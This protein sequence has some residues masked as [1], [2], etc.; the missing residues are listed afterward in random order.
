M[1]FPRK[2]RQYTFK[3]PSQQTPS[4]VTLSNYTARSHF[5]HLVLDS[6]ISM[7][8]PVPLDGHPAA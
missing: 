1:I 2:V 4:R 7:H 6:M 5:L 8:P 3:V